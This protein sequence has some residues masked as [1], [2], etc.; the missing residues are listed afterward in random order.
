MPYYY[1]VPK[2]LCFNSF[3]NYQNNMFICSTS[4]KTKYPY[5]LILYEFIIEKNEKIKI[6]KKDTKVGKYFKIAN[7]S[8]ILDC[9]LIS[10]TQRTNSLV[11]INNDIITLCSENKLN[12]IYN[13]N[14]DTCIGKINLII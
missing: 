12:N 4:F 11:K 14:I 1:Q 2:C 9:Y 5:K 8:L 6:I 7:T 3:L 13:K 10:S